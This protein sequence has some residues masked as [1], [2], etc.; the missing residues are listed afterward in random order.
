[1]VGVLRRHTKA[2]R[3]VVEDGRVRGVDLGE[4]EIVSAPVVVS[5]LDPSATF[6]GLMDREELPVA[7]ADRVGAF[8]HRAAYFRVHFALRRALPPRP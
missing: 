2:S 7:F 6:F 1:M 8:D 4:G 5:N 3:I